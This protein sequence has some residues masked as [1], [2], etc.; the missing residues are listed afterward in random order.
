MHALLLLPTKK[1]TVT[2]VV[3]CYLR[4]RREMVEILYLTL[5]S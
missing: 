1:S 2:V 5:N 3:T 4:A